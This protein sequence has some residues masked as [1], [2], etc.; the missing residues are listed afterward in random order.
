[1]YGQKRSFADPSLNHL[2]RAQQQFLRNGEPERLSGLHVDDQFEFRRLLH[3]DVAGLDALENFVDKYRRSAIEILQ[4]HS[5]TDQATSLYKVTEANRWKSLLSCKIR[6]RLGILD[7]YRILIEHDRI[8][9]CFVHS[10]HY[11]SNFSRISY[12]GRSKFELEQ[13][14]CTF[15]RL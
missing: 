9:V 10:R 11:T 3:R 14:G 6:N 15:H 12:L 1:M 5:V 7:K 13:R 2:V 4:I 8:D